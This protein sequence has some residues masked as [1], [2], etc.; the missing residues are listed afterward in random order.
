MR[1]GVDVRELQEGVQ[2][3][4][5]RMVEAFVSEAPKIRPEIR[6][7]LYADSTTRS[8]L[9]NTATELRTLYQ[10]A[11][12]WFDQVALPR[13]LATDGVD[14]FWSPYYKAPLFAPCPTVVTIHDVLFLRI[15]GI[16]AKNALFKPWARLIGSRAKVIL[17]DSEH[18]RRDLEESMGFDGSHVQVVPLGV[19]GRFSP[20]ARATSAALRQSHRIRQ[21]YVL[22]VTNFR[23]HKNDRLLL[24]A[25]SR[26]ASTDPDVDLVFAGRPAAKIG[27]LHES[28]AELRLAGRVHLPG[29]V[30]EDDLPALYAGATLFAFPS[31]YEGFGLPVLEAMSSGTPVLCSSASALPEIADDA[32][33]MLNPNDEGAWAEAMSRLLD[34][35]PSRQKLTRSGLERARAYTWQNTVEGI[36]SVL[37]RETA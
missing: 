1:I 37:E 31:L 35:E 8:N 24:R 33:I 3:G 32:A 34:D 10:P 36:L 22:T 27:D 2:T 18:S 26:V 23:A 11:T 5:G 7:V 4:I 29:L 25:F 30:P 17:T 28:I 14:V 12:M 16:R 6:L 15:G 19:S 20:G 9:S 21:R 13:A